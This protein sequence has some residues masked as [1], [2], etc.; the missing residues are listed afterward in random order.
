VRRA[1]FFCFFMAQPRGNDRILCRCAQPV[2]MA[3]ATAASPGLQG[4]RPPRGQRDRAGVSQPGPVP[5]PSPVL[6]GLIGLDDPKRALA[7][8]RRSQRLEQ[9]HPRRKRPAACVAP[10]PDRSAL[11]GSSIRR[12]TSRPSGLTTR[13]CWRAGRSEPAKSK[14]TWPRNGFGQAENA[15]V[16]RWVV[17]STPSGRKAGW[18]WS[19]RRCPLAGVDRLSACE[20]EAAVFPDVRRHAGA[21]AGEGVVRHAEDRCR[22]ASI[23]DADDVADRCSRPPQDPATMMLPLADRATDWTSSPNEASVQRGVELLVENTTTLP[24]VGLVQVRPPGWIRRRK[25]PVP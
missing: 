21:D 9:I 25:S 10:V 24:P 20:N 17:S 22:R 11:S 13:T 6:D 3:Q 4:S 1:G 8:R 2:R 12:L 23:V 7:L 5:V 19:S 14:V 18:P 16:E 15:G